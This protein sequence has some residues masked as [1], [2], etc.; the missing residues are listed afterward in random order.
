MDLGGFKLTQV[1]CVNHYQAINATSKNA[2]GSRIV[3]LCLDL[4]IEGG[5][6]RKSVI[7][8]LFTAQQVE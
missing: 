1:T 6:S 8:V 4:H 2:T 3:N 5:G 7:W